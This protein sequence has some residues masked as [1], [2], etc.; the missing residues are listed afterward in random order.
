MNNSSAAA[1]MHFFLNVSVKMNWYLAGNKQQMS[2]YV[3]A[4]NRNVFSL[5]LKVVTG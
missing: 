4:L 1:K 3:S 5:F 2:Y